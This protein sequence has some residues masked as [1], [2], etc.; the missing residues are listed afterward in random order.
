MQSAKIRIKNLE[1]INLK[2]I[3][4]FNTKEHLYLIINSG[5]TKRYVVTR[6]LETSEQSLIKKIDTTNIDFV[7]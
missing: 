3:P 2:I 7:R 5:E 1:N 4:Q 6:K